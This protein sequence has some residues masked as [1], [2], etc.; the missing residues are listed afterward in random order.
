MYENSIKT[1]P[2]GS[3]VLCDF[4]TGLC[5]PGLHASD[6]DAGLAYFIISL[7]SSIVHH[8]FIASGDFGNVK[9]LFAPNNVEGVDE[10]EIDLDSG[11][12]NGLLDHLISL[13]YINY[14]FS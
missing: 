11:G 7:V 2:T 9:Y 5:L 1:T 8:S 4:V 12:L 10:F 3:P 13:K 6:A 14:H